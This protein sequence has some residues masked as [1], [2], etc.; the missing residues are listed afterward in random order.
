[1]PGIWW[2]ASYPKSGNTWMRAFLSSLASD[3]P[4]NIN[5]F[6]SE[7]SGIASSRSLLDDALGIESG[8]LTDDLQMSLRPRAYEVIAASATQPVYLK[9]HDTYGETPSLEPLFPTAATAG[10]VYI[11]R[12]PLDVAVSFAHYSASSMAS[13]VTALLDRCGRL[14]AQPRSLRNQLCQYVSDWASHVDSWLSAPFPVHLVRYEDLLS[15]PE[16]AFGSVVAFL[17]RNEGAQEIR[18]AIHECAFGNLSRQEGEAGFCSNSA[19]GNSFFR[20][21]VAGAW[22][23]EL[24]TQEAQRLLSVF[25]PT[26]QRL[27]YSLPAI[28][29]RPANFSDF[30]ALK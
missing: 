1:M 11:V 5:E 9:V 6:A 13:S 16:S 7:C 27:G 18:H 2:L 30:A 24:P 22:R 28:G 3:A 25:A 10:A 15:D 17:R 8:D 21:G 29:K 26:M 20:R 4:L 23:D 14:G 19:S 12:N